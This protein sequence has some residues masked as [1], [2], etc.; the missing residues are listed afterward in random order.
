MICEKKRQ[1][2]L[3][4]FTITSFRHCFVFRL[5]E[6]EREPREKQKRGGT[7]ALLTTQCD[8]S[9]RKYD[10][11]TKCIDDFFRLILNSVLFVRHYSHHSHTC[12]GQTLV[13][14][15][16]YSRRSVWM[17][18]RVHCLFLSSVPFDCLLNEIF[19]FDLIFYILFSLAS[20]L[21]CMRLI[22]WHKLWSML[23]RAF[24]SLF[25]VL[26]EKHVHT[27][28]NLCWRLV[29]YVS[30]KLLAQAVAHCSSIASIH[31]YKLS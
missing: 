10:L 19:V 21:L 22:F 20:V 14:F 13:K 3:R 17:L 7:V 31:L 9:N 6:N 11:S 8:A 27:A 29:H 5:T 2:G 4:S 24:S 28:A 25:F 30:H 18:V 26:F 15:V 1:H 23:W 12:D 16:L